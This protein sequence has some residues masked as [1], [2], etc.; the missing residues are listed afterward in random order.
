ML[1]VL[2]EVK[3]LLFVCVGELSVA[4]WRKKKH[5][6]IETS[7]IMWRPQ[8]HCVWTHSKHIGKSE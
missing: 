4:L 5:T 2:R 6:D 1:R 3:G 7:Q 8:L